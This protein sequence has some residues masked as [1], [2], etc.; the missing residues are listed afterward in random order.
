MKKQ[1]ENKMNK[2]ELKEFIDRI[3]QGRKLC[4]EVY[5]AKRVVTDEVDFINV[6]VDVQGEEWEF[7]YKTDIFIDWA[8]SEGL[9]KFNWFGGEKEMS[10]ENWI[11]LTE[12]ESLIPYTKMFLFEL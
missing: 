5:N 12:D 4:F 1:T 6:E 3:T 2:Q 11:N 8:F 9:H 10:R 7:H